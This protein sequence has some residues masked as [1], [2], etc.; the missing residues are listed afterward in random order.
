M[1]SRNIRKTKEN[2]RNLIDFFAENG[3]VTKR[4]S[5]KEI[6]GIPIIESTREG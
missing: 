1:N 2:R 6:T 3:R 5:Y 4:V